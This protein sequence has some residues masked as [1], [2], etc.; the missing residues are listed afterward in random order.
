VGLAH[1][2]FYLHK[3]MN[4]FGIVCGDIKASNIMLE[5]Y[6]CAKIANI[7]FK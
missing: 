5:K 4:L 3:K 1:G 6:L 7:G 2:I